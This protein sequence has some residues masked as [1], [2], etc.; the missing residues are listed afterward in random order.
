MVRKIVRLSV[1]RNERKRAQA[2]RIYRKMFDVCRDASKEWGDDIAGFAVV[3]WNTRGGTLTGYDTTDG[4]VD[5]HV[6]PNVVAH[7]LHRHVTLDD[8][9]N[10]DSEEDSE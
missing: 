4:P 5:S 1:V 3:A 7:A 8:I 2:K 9:N 10:R 6:M